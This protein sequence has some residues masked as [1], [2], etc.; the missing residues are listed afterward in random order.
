MSSSNILK[1]TAPAN[2]SG[3]I[4]V[5]GQF[6]GVNTGYTTS[7]ISNGDLNTIS[8]GGINNSLKGMC[9]ATNNGIPEIKFS[10]VMADGAP[11]FAVFEP[12]ASMTASDLSRVMVLVVAF[13]SASAGV[14]VNNVKPITYI[15]SNNL[16]RHFRFSS[17]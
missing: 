10:E 17:V 9:V 12:E 14:L 4:Y 1:A 13:Q 2:T 15:R 6:G 11:V 16:E 8:A 3:T 7:F 5:S